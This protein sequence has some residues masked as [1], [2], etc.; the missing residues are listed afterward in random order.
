MTNAA[1]PR[2][3]P[4][5]PVSLGTVSGWLHGDG[6]RG[7]LMCGAAGFEAMSVYQ[8]WRVLADMLAARGYSVL[9][10][11]YPG[12]GDSGDRS[13]AFAAEAMAALRAAG[14]LLHKLTGQPIDMLSL[15]LGAVL[16]EVAFENDPRIA[17]RV[18][19]APVASGR[20]FLRETK[21]AAQIFASQ[22]G[23]ETTLAE[24]G[25]SLCGHALDQADCAS[26][27]TLRYPPP[28]DGD[29]LAVLPD[30]PA[31]PDLPALTTRLTFPGYAAMLSPAEAEPPL[32]TFTAIA[33]WL[34]PADG[35]RLTAPEPA[36]PIAG[37]G[38]V[39]ER[40]RF[41]PENRL[42]GTWCRPAN[43]QTGC[44]VIL[45]NAGANPRFGW[46]R[47]SVVHARAL[48]RQ[49][50]ASLRFDLSGLGD[51]DWTGQSPRKALYTL[52]HLDNMDAAIALASG[53]GAERITLAGLCSGGHLALHA[54]DR[55]PAVTGVV[56][57]N[58]L[59]IIWR[60]GVDDLDTIERA[61]PQASRH[62]AQQ[63]LSSS[64]WKRL[65]SGE[66]ALSR[67]LAVG[68]MLVKKRIDAVLARLGW[69]RPL[70]PESQA[71]RALIRRL[72]S[73]GTSLSF[74]YGTLDAS[75]D[76]AERH[77]GSDGRFL[78][79]LPGVTTTFIDDTDHELTPKH[80]RDRLEVILA[81]RALNS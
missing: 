12:E 70:S 51:S 35:Q 79:A 68:G 22:P 61:A 72:A 18:M 74:V 10:I 32:E 8:G 33:D 14:D 46:A 64:Y 60:Q 43:R 20:I 40:L 75:R 7:I 6:A 13:A 59:K 71:A 28:A 57:V 48:A 73:R 25:V 63:A 24:A 47:M 80:A 78:A 65:F 62:Y 26:I 55:N 42:V 49:G 41:G 76:E 52:A 53:R 1:F 27:E 15:R 19:L 30:G 44:C 29:V 4:P 54:A 23:R 9:R 50:V 31:A 36:T 21:L 11:D 58:V 17:R 39:E 5:V 81:D 38:F 3:A 45:P 66:I 69:E 77:F 2:P 67:I 56:A 34:G 37:P 16:A